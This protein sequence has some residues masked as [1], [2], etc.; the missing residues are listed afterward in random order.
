[1]TSP[2][3]IGDC[4]LY[5]GDCLEV[6]PTLNPVNC[7]VTDPPYPVTPTSKNHFTNPGMIK[8]GWM[9]N[10]YPMG[11]GLMFECPKFD[12]WLPL[13]FSAA[14]ENADA[15]IMSNDKNLAAM[16][17][18]ATQCNWKLHN[19]LVW[20][21]PTGVPNRWYFK[22]C[23]FTLYLWKGKAKT[24]RNPGSTQTFKASHTKER[25]HP[26]QK[27]TALFQHY[28]ENSTDLGDVV[29][30]PFMG[31][32]TAGVACAKLG[33]KFIGIETDRKH[34]DIACDRIGQAYIQGDLFVSAPMQPVQGA[35]VL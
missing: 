30:D 28:I 33:R 31:S 25:K 10:E 21:K 18:A 12:D 2:V 16:Q 14:D 13:A 9:M 23:E 6:M 17:I 7:I 27:P 5:S 29:L 3:V 34:F 22:D 26:S 8:S 15:Y 24:I 1:M 20:Q 11:D 35:L 4:T 32:G 19:V